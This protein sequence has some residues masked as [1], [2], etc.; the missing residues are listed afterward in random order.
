MAFEYLTTNG[1]IEHKNR[2]EANTTVTK[3]L[4]YD[5]RPLVAHNRFQTLY[6]QDLRGER[7]DLFHVSNINFSFRWKV[8]L[9]KCVDA[10]PLILQTNTRG[11]EYYIYIGAHNSAFLCMYPALPFVDE[12]VYLTMERHCGR[13]G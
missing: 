1:V 12:K 7:E 5:A 8:L 6:F 9:G 3:Q 4:Q 2:E 10:S 13:A 11:P